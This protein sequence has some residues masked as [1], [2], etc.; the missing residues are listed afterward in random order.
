MIST[1]VDRR[2][3]LVLA[4]S[5]TA[6]AACS[7]AAVGPASVGDVPAGNVSS[8]PV[9][10]LRVVDSQ[11]VCIGRDSSGVYAM[12]LTCTHAG[13]DIGQTGTV[14]PQGLQCACHGSRFDANGNVVSGPASAPL[15][16]FA[17]TVDSSGNLTIHGGQVVDSGQRLSVSG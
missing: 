12:T 2:R 13:C 14:S 10:A 17:V 15:D 8:L 1:Q 11:P 7:S 6:T 5:A 3:F 9:D 4:G 16:H